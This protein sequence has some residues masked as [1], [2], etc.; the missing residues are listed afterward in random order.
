MINIIIG[1]RNSYKDGW[2][3]ELDILAVMWNR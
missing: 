3:H 1:L 2:A